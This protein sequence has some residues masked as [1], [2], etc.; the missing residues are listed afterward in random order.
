M[1]KILTAAMRAH[2]DAETTRLAVIW[3]ITRKDGAQFFFTDH[4]RDIVFG[5]DTYRADAGFARTAIRSDAGFAVDNLDLVGVFAEGGIVED[6]VRAGLFDGAEIRVS[7]V[8]WDDPDGHGEIRLRRGTLGETRL[9]PQGY[10]HAELR[11]LSQPLAQSTLEVFSPNCR[12][13]LGDERCKFPIEPPELGRDQAVSEGAFYRVPTAA[14]TGSARYEDRI[15]EVIEAGTTAAS[16]PA[17]DTTIGATT[18]DGTATLKAYDTHGITEQSFR[19]VDGDTL[20]VVASASFSSQV[21][22]ATVSAYT[23]TGRIDFALALGFLSAPARIFFAND[24]SV[25]WQGQ[26]VSTRPRGVVAGISEFGFC[27]AWFAG[28]PSIVLGA[29]TATVSILHVRLELPFAVSPVTGFPATVKPTAIT[30]TAASLGASQMTI[31]NLCYD[32]QNDRLLFISVLDGV[33]HLV[34]YSAASG[35][36]WYVPVSG[37]LPHQA[38]FT[39][40][41][42]RMVNGTSVITRSADDGSLISSQSGFTGTSGIVRFDPRTGALYTPTSGSGIEQWLAGRSADDS[43]LLGDVVTSLCARVGLSAADLDVTELTDEVHGFGRVTAGSRIIIGAMIRAAAYSARRRSLRIGGSRYLGIVSGLEEG[44][45]A[46][47]SPYNAANAFKRERKSRRRA[48]HL[49]GVTAHE[50]FMY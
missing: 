21:E 23:L 44:R 33:R 14:G 50:I 7:F 28:A 17:Y 8:H 35:I 46:S 24:L 9:T 6:E 20:Q 4:D 18:A 38:R 48:G 2:L 15:Y 30:L 36:V 25:F 31:G 40:G 12:A 47:N 34:S 5:G 32:E 3:R 45:D 16:Q 37:D 10:F 39:D 27:E 49:S 43:A 13:D 41:K 11:G 26:N 1:P 19:K 42:I 22:L 29:P